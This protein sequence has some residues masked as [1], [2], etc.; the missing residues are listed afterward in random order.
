MLS[1]TMSSS[2][3]SLSSR[4]TSRHLRL[5][6]PT[7]IERLTMTSC[8]QLDGVVVEPPQVVLRRPKTRSAAI[9]QVVNGP[10]LLLAAAQ[11]GNE[12]QTHRLDAQR[13][14]P[15]IGEDAEADVPIRVNVR[16]NRRLPNE[17]DLGALCDGNGKKSTRRWGGKQWR[18]RPVGACVRA[19]DWGKT[20][21]GMTSKRSVGDASQA[22]PCC[23]SGRVGMTEGVAGIIDC[24]FPPQ[25]PQYAEGADLHTRGRAGGCN[26]SG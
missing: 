26:I 22:S 6:R 3:P 11:H 18:K 14:A 1:S 23:T 13:R 21:K 8:E 17:H 5:L 2:S 24:P 12:R 7:I 20:R 10:L 15:P 19:R 25:R 16:V 9:C 4:A